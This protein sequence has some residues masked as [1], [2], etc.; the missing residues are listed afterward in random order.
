MDKRTLASQ[1]LAN[2]GNTLTAG[3]LVLDDA[4]QS[5]VLM[6]DDNLVLNIEYD[7]A[8]GRLVLSCYL[9][10]L[11]RDGAE[12]LLRELLAANLYWHRTRGAT[13]GL[14]EGTG[15]VILTYG[16]GVSELDGPAF[17]TVV[18]NFMNQAERWRGR[19]AA[20]GASSAP[21]VTVDVPA[22]PFIPPSFA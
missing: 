6:F 12:P 16:H 18:E 4:T 15:G 2:L 7:D 22:A 5:C 14:E 10:E 21:S 19:I 13:L 20:A 9:D 8:Q 1:L 17:E 3:P 11:P